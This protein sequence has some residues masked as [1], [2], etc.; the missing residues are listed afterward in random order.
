MTRTRLRNWY[1]KTSE[2]KKELFR[3]QKEISF[4]SMNCFSSLNENEIVD[5]KTF[6]K[7]VKPFLSNKAIFLQRIVLHEN[8][9]LINNAAMRIGGGSRQCRSKCRPMLDLRRQ[10]KLPP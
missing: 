1:F 4:T 5:N 3:K 8:K 9:L 2:E 10:K 6:W 7:T